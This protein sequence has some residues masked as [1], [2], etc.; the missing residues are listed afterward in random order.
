[1]KTKIL[2]PLLLTLILIS[3]ARG[4]GIQPFIANPEINT[5][6][7]T[8][9]VVSYSFTQNV[10]S[11]AYSSG[12][13]VWQVTTDPLVTTFT[14]SA[15][16]K[17]IWHLTISYTMVVDQTLTIAIF[18][19][20][21]PVDTWSY[22][23]ETDKII[24]NFDVTV[25]KQ[26]QYPTAEELADKAVEVFRNELAEI[27]AEMREQNELSRQHDYFQWAVVMIT[28][29]GLIIVLVPKFRVRKVETG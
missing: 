15:A 28:F 5:F 1:V 7:E 13:S 27:I 22:P 14:T 19:G 24:L 6:I 16:D 17:F 20:D 11:N 29:F 25:T 10:T 12:Q 26:P 2:L 8:R 23:I 4:N 21:K 3:S 9:I 18:S